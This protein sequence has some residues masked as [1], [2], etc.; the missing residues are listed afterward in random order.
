[1]QPTVKVHS[2]WV[3]CGAVRCS[4]AGLDTLG[5]GVEHFLHLVIK[6]LINKKV[7]NA[8][9]VQYRV[10]ID[11]KKQTRHQEIKQ[12]LHRLFGHIGRA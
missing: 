12:R 3:R 4:A 7:T 11:H 9:V 8:H 1:M 5:Y 6:S 2:H 10:N